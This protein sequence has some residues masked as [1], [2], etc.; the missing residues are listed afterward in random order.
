MARQPFA[1]LVNI[2]AP[3]ESRALKAPLTI[4]A[5]GWGQCRQSWGSIDDAR[6]QAMRD[7]VLV[8]VGPR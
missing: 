3:S 5:G 1:A 8:A 6:Y 2:A 4:A 7:R